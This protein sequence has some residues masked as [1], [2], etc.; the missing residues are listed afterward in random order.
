MKK[1]ALQDTEQAAIAA[2]ARHFRAGRD[3][4]HLRLADRRIAV[5]V[6]LL[7]PKAASGAVKPRLRFDRVVLRLLGDLQAALEKSVPDGEAVI[8]TV[9]APIRLPGRTAVALEEKIRGVL[10]GK[11]SARDARFAVHGNGVRLRRVA[12]MP[13]G[14]PKLTGFVHNADTDPGMILDLTEALMRQ[15]GARAAKR[16]AR[17]SKDERWLILAGET[18]FRHG[19][20]YRQIW[21]QVAIPT[22]FAKIL[23][24]SGSGKVE[25]LAG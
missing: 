2:V 6:A 19:E 16:W 10:A 8:L 14:M 25:I 3:G 21:S 17:V 22:G 1:A 12:D 7:G 20:V 11:P 4:S 5:E 9:T 15:V 18:D 23:L 13:A 24:V